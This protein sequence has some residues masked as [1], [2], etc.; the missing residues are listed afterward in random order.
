MTLVKSLHKMY[1]PVGWVSLLLLLGSAAPIDSWLMK[2]WPLNSCC[3]PAAVGCLLLQGEP[4]G[5]RVVMG[6]AL[7]RIPSR[8]E[9]TLLTNLACINVAEDS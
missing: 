5:H 8:R 9:V 2:L 6:Q 3:R 1:V 7:D 4:S